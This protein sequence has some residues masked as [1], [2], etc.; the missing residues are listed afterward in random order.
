M[1]GR[2]WNGGEGDDAV[3]RLI[4][5][6]PPEHVMLSYQW[7]DQQMVKQVA[8]FLKKKE[9]LVWLDI[10]GGM[11]GNINQAMA[12]GVERACVVFSFT[13]PAYARSPNCNKE[14]NYAF[15]LKKRIVLVNVD[16]AMDY[17]ANGPLMRKI[18]ASIDE[19]SKV[20]LPLPSAEENA[21][22]L[23]ALEDLYGIVV[24]EATKKAMNTMTNT[25]TLPPPPADI[26]QRGRAAGTFKCNTVDGVVTYNLFL[27]NIS[28]RKGVVSGYGQYQ[29][30]GMATV[31][32][33]YNSDNGVSFQMEFEHILPTTYF[34]GSCARKGGNG[35]SITGLCSSSEGSFDDERLTF[36]LKSREDGDDGDDDNG[37]DEDNGGIY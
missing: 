15:Q 4:R 21:L 7:G 32:G 14:I 31:T 36:M 34:N 3:I 5:V 26:Y 12:S 11:K 6:P 16:G 23:K 28:L 22:F 2:W 20:V 33:S 13:T 10:D 19:N 9:V 29:D 25:T 24:D 30:T 18:A 37:G 17:Q 1:T 8:A 35:F 27:H